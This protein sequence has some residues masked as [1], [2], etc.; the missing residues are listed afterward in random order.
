VT[1][2]ADKRAELV[3]LLREFIDAK[4]QTLI[5]ISALI[6]QRDQLRA[7]VAAMKRVLEREFGDGPPH[8]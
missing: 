2:D 4:E 3:A 7:D 6:E 8:T 5:K 1:D